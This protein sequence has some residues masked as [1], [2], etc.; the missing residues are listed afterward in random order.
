MQRLLLRILPHTLMLRSMI[1]WRL[2]I[3]IGSSRGRHCAALAGRRISTSCF[4]TKAFEGI[5]ASSRAAA[6]GKLVAFPK[7]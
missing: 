3:D 2:S 4:G 7:E 6:V 5:H 1:T